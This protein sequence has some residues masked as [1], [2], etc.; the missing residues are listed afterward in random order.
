[1]ARLNPQQYEAVHHTEGPLLVL[2]GAGSGKT[3]VITSRIVHLLKNKRV[4]AKR[5]WPLPLPTRL[6]RRC[7]SG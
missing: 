2:A 4:P 3:Q 6:P 5:S 1:M 7:N